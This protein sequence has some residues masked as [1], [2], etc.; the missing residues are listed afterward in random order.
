[1][2]LAPVRCRALLHSLLPTD[3]ACSSSCLST[4]VIKFCIFSDPTHKLSALIIIIIIIIVV[5]YEL[6]KRN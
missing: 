1:M 2:R 6:S 3:D 5:Y 4:T